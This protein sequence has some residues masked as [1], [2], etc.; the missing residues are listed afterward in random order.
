M[1]PFLQMDDFANDLQGSIQP[2]AQTL[3]QEDNSLRS[4]EIGATKD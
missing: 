4:L 2:R 1:K 3:H